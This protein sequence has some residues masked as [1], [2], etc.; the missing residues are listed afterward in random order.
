VSFRDMVAHYSDPWVMGL[1]VLGTLSCAFHFTN[2]LNGF[3]WTW[4][5]AVGEKSRKWV[6]LLSWALFVA[7]AIPFLHILYSFRV[8]A[9]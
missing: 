6:E 5:I 7:L 2:G 8:A 9:P 3:C 4:G 1:Y